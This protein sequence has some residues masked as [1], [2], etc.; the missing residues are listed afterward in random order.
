MTRVSLAIAVAILVMGAVVAVR[1]VQHESALEDSIGKL[2]DDGHFTTSTEAGN[3]I[4]NISVKLRQSGASCRGS[5]K[6]APRCSA[7]LS[8]AAYAAVTA[9]TVLDCTAPGVYDARTAMLKYLRAVRAYSKGALPSVPE[10]VK[11]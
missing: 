10:V 1:A 5:D 11:C 2:E 9:Y 6:D 4:A 7:V 8:A 3:T